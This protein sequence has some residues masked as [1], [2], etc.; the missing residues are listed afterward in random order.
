MVRPPML[1]ALAVMA[2]MLACRASQEGD[3]AKG[4]AVFGEQC[5]SCH[6]ATG[7]E[8]KLA[9]GLKGIFKAAKLNSGK[10]ATEQNVRAQVD[11][12]GNGMPSY[13]D[14]LTDREK[15]DLIAYLKTL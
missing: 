4:N 11:D 1:A 13:K 15:D 2:G 10:K 6:S 5:A 12:G 7:A 8:K 9:P 14:L 3:A